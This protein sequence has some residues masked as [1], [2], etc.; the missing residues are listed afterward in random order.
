VGLRRHEAVGLRIDDLKQ[1]EEYWAIVDLVGKAGHVRTVPIP[2]W[3]KEQK[4]RMAEG[5]WNWPRQDLSQGHQ[6]GAN[7]GRLHDGKVDLAY[8]EGLREKNR[9]A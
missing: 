1:R 9:Y 4:R 6:D 8:C 2:D 5:G 7:M 3:V